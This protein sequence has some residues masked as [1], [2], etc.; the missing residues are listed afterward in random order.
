MMMPAGDV[1]AGYGSSA[2]RIVVLPEASVD[3]GGQS[4]SV[5]MQAQIG[6]D[7]LR[8]DMEIKFPQK[9][10][11]KIKKNNIVEKKVFGSIISN[12]FTEQKYPEPVYFQMLT[13][14]GSQTFSRDMSASRSSTSQRH[15]DSACKTDIEC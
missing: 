7:S 12:I 1:S 5:P 11:T 13:A 2:G 8:I 15:R 4:M 10:K 14:L 9:E 3:M 6:K